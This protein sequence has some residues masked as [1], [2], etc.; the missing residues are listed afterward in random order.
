M[1]YKILN[2]KENF[3]KW[4]NLILKLPPEFQDIYFQ[5]EYVLMSGTQKSEPILFL[6]E[7]EDRYWCYSFL[8]NKIDNN[9]INY[10][11]KKFY[12]LESPYGYSGPLSNSNDILFLD[13]AQKI[14][15]DW[16]N[17]NHVVAEFVRFHPFIANQKYY[18]SL[19]SIEFNR[20]TISHS[21]PFRENTNIDYKNKTKNII[22][23]FNKKNFNQITTKSFHRFSQFVDLYKS[24]IIKKNVSDFYLFREDY[25]S[26]LYDIL[27]KCGWLICVEN[28]NSDLIG[29]SVFLQGKQFLHYHLAAS[30][31]KREYSGVNN[32][33]LDVAIKKAKES[34]LKGIHLGG[35]N[36]TSLNDSLLKFKERMGN[37][38]NE[39]YIGRKIHNKDIYQQIKNKW[40]DQG[41]AINNNKILFYK[42]N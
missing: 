22:K 17:A 28:S 27:C 9:L 34:K 18:N 3:T 13:R 19:D 4:K 32:L 33:I 8:K 16:C 15:A 23:H 24:S 20:I 21:F 39:F 25:F 36:T 6:Y 26:Y 11:S 5:P 29:G 31:K 37:T 30:Q 41:K 35:G 1:K 12:D 40:H 7:E 10:D 42:N 14:F 38:K 2:A